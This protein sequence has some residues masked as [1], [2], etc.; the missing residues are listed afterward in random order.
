MG[1][2]QRRILIA[3]LAIVSHPWITLG[4]VAL[5]VAACT[6]AAL[7]WL[8][9]SSSQNE[10]FSDKPWFFHDYLEYINRFKENEALYIVIDAK[11]PNDK[12]AVADWTAVANAVTDRLR[13][14]TD[15]VLDAYCR[16]PL[17]QLGDQALL[18]QDPAKLPNSFS[19]VQQLAQLTAI[20][21]AKPSFLISALGKNPIERSLS[22]AVAR[23]DAQ[24]ASFIS[25]LAQSW[26]NAI[27]NP[28]KPLAVGDGVTDFR[29]I[30]ASSPTDLGYFYVPDQTDRS[31]HR[32]IVTVYPRLEHE[33]LT[34]VTTT[35]NAIRDAAVSAGSQ[36][37]RFQIGVTGRPALEADQ[38]QTTDVDSHKAEIVALAV[39]FIGMAFMLQSLWLALAAEISLC[40][41]IGWSFGWATL[42]IGRLNLLSLV[43]LIALIGIGMDYLVQ[44]LSRYRREARRYQRP[45]AV[46]TS[47]FKFVGPPI[48]TACLGAAG[49]FFVA[50][51][52][53]F[54]GASELGII[55]GGG[56]LLCL[57]A[58]Y[59]VLPAL[60]TIFP[61]KLK[62]L[63]VSLRFTPVKPVSPR[64]LAL[65]IVWAALLLAG[66]RFMPDAHFD[67]DLIKL[68]VPDLPSV[69]LIRTLQTWVGVVMSKD[70]DQLRQVRS[71]VSGLSVVT[72]T[73][74]VLNAQ[75]NLAWLKAHASEVPKIQ[76]TDPEP[77]TAGDLPNLSQKSRNLSSVLKNFP[78]AAQVLAQ[79]ADDLDHLP[80]DS[81]PDSTAAAA[82]QLSIWQRIFVAQIK[83]LMAQFTPSKL[84]IPAL[85]HQLRN[86]YFNDGYYALFIYPVKDLWNDANLNQFE[87]A[88]ESAVAKVP[89]APHVTGIS[90]DVYHTTEATHDAFFHSTVYALALIFFLVFLDF[91]RLIPTLAAISVLALGLPML[92]ALMG[93]FNVSWNFANFFGL[94]ILIGAGHEY[95][96]FMVHRF[97][98]AKQNPR[99]AWRTWDVSDRAL[100]LCAYITSSS[101]G[102]F[103]LL[104]HHQGLKS[105]GLVMAL[106]TACIY[107][108]T[109]MALRPLLK[110]RLRQLNGAAPSHHLPSFPSPGTPG[111]G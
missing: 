79:F 57:T 111:E 80:S 55:A 82:K 62:H 4:V 21:G 7:N 10:L 23:P 66:S 97:E 54:R 49:A 72:S 24:T 56:L 68:Q 81:A 77:V 26:D 93:L 78:T 59:V 14:L 99:R 30:G 52:T 89:G 69:Q 38:M 96:V 48:N 6:G 20:W 12:P 85:P 95:G 42:A 76:W 70:P 3:V 61:P 94:P 60:L 35:I 88:V 1:F 32:I 5:T 28:T 108:A 34:S 45:K 71:A 110:W 74:S 75:D 9:I 22:G 104:A 18:F 67:P 27:R 13:S 91:R 107:L 109:V 11:D 44:I 51:F 83:D 103:W 17:P 63:D 25:Q 46:W 15:H 36:F 47:V 31:R 98:E 50:V 19:S 73:D 84:D 90:S 39:V 106:G 37:P 58:G 29:A 105:L 101:F 102:F 16:I 86:H 92:V 40:V 41:G 53:D 87:F 2:L 100:L 65:P 33:S 64:I 43:F 8:T